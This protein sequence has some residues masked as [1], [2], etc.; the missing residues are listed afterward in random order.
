MRLSLGRVI[1]ILGAIALLGG[2]VYGFMPRPIDVDF[3][4]VAFG[5]LLVSVSEDGKTRIKEKYIVSMPFPGRIDRVLLDPGDEVTAGESTLITIQPSE[6]DPLNERLE[7]EAEARLQASEAALK[8]AK[9]TAEK[10]AAEKEWADTNFERIRKL[11]DQNAATIE[12]R[13]DAE[14]LQRS[15][16][17]DAEAAQFAV[18][19]AEFEVAMAQAAL[20]RA[21]PRQGRSTEDWMYQVASPV[22][23]KVLRVFQESA[24][25]LATGTP[26]IEIG[27]PADL[28]M[29]IDVLSQDAVQIRP[30][31]KVYVEHWGGDK[32]LIGTVRL[33]E[34]GGFT[35][36]SALGV[37]EQRVNVIADFSVPVSE[38]VT[39]GDAYRVDARIALWESDRVLQVPSSAL[40]RFGEEWC[41]FVVDKSARARRQVVQ[42]GHRN[43]QGAEIL[44]GLSEGNRVILHPGDNL[45]DG[46]LVSERPRP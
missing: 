2:V 46:V 10:A 37:E 29:E 32:V 6:P 43:A 45:K 34:P 24:A 3:G 8:R 18:E 23:G 22:S 35:K 19:I 33:V 1:G 25:T 31:A 14:L 12:R 44:G 9:A 36:I 16:A 11:H 41:V 40:F 5:P 26:V 17:K 4:D 30:G 20:V 39:L 42:I 13:V 15:R 38:R 21:K 28:E 7:L 27:D